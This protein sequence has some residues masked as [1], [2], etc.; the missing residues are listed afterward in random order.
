MGAKADDTPCHP[1]FHQMDPGSEVSRRLLLLMEWSSC[2][3]ELVSRLDDLGEKR[4]NTAGNIA[5]KVVKI[6]INKEPRSGY[7]AAV[8]ESKNDDRN[9]EAT[10]SSETSS[11]GF[12]KGKLSRSVDESY[13]SMCSQHFFLSDLVPFLS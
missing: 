13:S 8:F 2:L 3:D 7:H 4:G 10:Y 5:P 11:G 12:N 6:N 1:G 9:I